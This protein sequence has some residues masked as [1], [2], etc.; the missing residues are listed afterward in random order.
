MGD[1]DQ[2]RTKGFSKDEANYKT[3]TNAGESAIICG[4]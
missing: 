2:A 4:I 1:L 3:K